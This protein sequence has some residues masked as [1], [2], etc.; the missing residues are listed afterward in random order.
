MGRFLGMKSNYIN[1]LT[2]LGLQRQQ[3]D[4]DDIGARLADRVEDAVRRG[5]GER[6][7]GHRRFRAVEDDV[8]RLLD[9]D[10]GFADPREDCRE[11]PDAVEV[12]DDEETAGG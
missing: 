10:P 9:V 1:E 5:F 11:D 12:T 8:L 3:G 7:P 6:D 4:L 2:G